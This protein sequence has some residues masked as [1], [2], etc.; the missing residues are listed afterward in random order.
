MPVALPLPATSCMPLFP[1]AFCMYHFPCP[2]YRSDPSR[3]RTEFWIHPECGAELAAFEVVYTKILHA[4]F[5]SSD[6]AVYAAIVIVLI[7]LPT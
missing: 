2:G 4:F 1:A 3:N 5:I 7:S 6:W